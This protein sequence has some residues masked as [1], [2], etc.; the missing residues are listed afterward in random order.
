MLF[1]VEGFLGNDYV[2]MLDGDR[3]ARADLEQVVVLRGDVPAAPR[4][5]ATTSSAWRAGRA[6]PRSTTASAALGADDL[7]DLLFTSGTTGAP[8]GV[9][10]THGQTVRAFADWA[11]IVGL[12][13]DDRYLVVNPFFHS[14]GYKA[15]IVAVAHQVGATIVPGRDLRRAAR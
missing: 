1:T 7:C 3:R 4:S 5:A 11:S 9:M 6:R 15:G 14:F 8:K 2:S 10:C 13:G 12:R